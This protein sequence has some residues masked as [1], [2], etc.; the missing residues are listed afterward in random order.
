MGGEAGAAHTGDARFLDDLHDLVGGQ[1][2]VVGMGGELGAPGI[3]EVV[4]DHHRQGL[5]AAHVG[6]GLHRLDLAGDRGVDGGAQ[7]G[8]LAD[9][10]PHLYLVSDGHDGLAGRADMHGHGDDD[11]LGSRAERRDLLAACQLLPVMGMHAAVKALL[12]RSTSQI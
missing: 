4:L 10:L 7:T 3:L 12:H 9:L 11:L 8:D 2:A 1:A 6:T 5:A